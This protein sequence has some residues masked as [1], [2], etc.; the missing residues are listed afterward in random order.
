MD[1]QEAVSQIMGIKALLPEHLQ[2]KLIEAVKVL[3]N[4]KMISVDDD[5]PYNHPHL[6]TKLGSYTLGPQ[7]I[8]GYKDGQF[9][10]DYMRQDGDGYWTWRYSNEDVYGKIIDWLPTR[11]L[12]GP[13][14]MD[15]FGN[16]L[17]IE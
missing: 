10:F 5:M 4:F 17:K 6:I 12:Y 16:E 11:A 1:K 3:A 15:E 13:H 14:I 2:A 8:V 9:R 7:C